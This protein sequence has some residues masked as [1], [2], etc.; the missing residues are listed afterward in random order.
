MSWL[1]EYR[2][3]Q[4]LLVCKGRMG[5]VSIQTPPQPG[6]GYE[7]VEKEDGTHL[8]MNERTHDFGLVVDRANSMAD[9]ISKAQ[10]WRAV[11]SVMES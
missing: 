6:G 8:M 7:Y 10:N 1:A 4:E 3:K 9:A 2:R 11:V 5:V